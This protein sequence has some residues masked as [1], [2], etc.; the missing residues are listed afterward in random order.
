MVSRY[1]RWQHLSPKMN[2]LFQIV[3]SRQ[4]GLEE[5]YLDTAERCERLIK[6]YAERISYG[7]DENDNS[8]FAFELADLAIYLRWYIMQ[9]H[10]QK[11]FNTFYTRMKVFSFISCKIIPHYSC[12]SILRD[13]HLIKVIRPGDGRPDFLGI[14][15]GINE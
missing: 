8:Q 15:E 11:D 13:Y 12:N 10:T 7:K 2:Q 6:I 4:K 1:N 5:E 14:L 3:R 9:N